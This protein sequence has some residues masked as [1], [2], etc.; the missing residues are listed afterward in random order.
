[1]CFANINVVHQSGI[2]N[3]SCTSKLYRSAT[4]SVQ[5]HEWA[6]PQQSTPWSFR[7]QYTHPMKEI[8]QLSNTNFRQISI[9]KRRQRVVWNPTISRCSILCRVE[10]NCT[11][12]V[13]KPGFFSATR[14]TLHYGVGNCAWLTLTDRTV[15]TS[16]RLI[17]SRGLSLY[18]WVQHIAKHILNFLDIVSS[19]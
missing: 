2:W 17:P 9:D 10:C 13:C 18:L 19:R 6:T 16:R 12:I 4:I 11:Y 1:M 3:Y 7:N 8:M 5:N 15:S 14:I